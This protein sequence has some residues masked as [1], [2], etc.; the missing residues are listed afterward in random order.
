MTKG[1]VF[2]RTVEEH[3]RRTCSKITSM[4]GM[5]ESYILIIDIKGDLVSFSTKDLI[6]RPTNELKRPEVTPHYPRR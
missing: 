3:V 1:P 6:Y 5:T 2:R 4:K